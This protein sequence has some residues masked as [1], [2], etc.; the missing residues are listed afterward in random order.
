MFKGNHIIT[1]K[2]EHSSVINTFKW[3]E[4]F[5]F[6]VTYLDVNKDG[7]VEL[8]TLEKAIKENTVFISI[9]LINN[10]IGTI[11]DINELA[12]FANSKN[13]IFH[14]DVVQAVGHM[15]IDVNKLNC[16][17]L[18]ASSHKFNGPK[19]CG[20]LYKK[21]SVNI[22]P[23]IHGGE[24]EFG[25]RGV[26]DNLAQIEAMTIAL[27]GSIDY[28]TEYKAYTKS[29]R[30]RFL[31]ELKETGLN[32]VINGGDKILNSI[33]SISFRDFDGEVILHRLQFKG[34]YVSTGSACDSEKQ[35]VSHV[36]K[37]INLD[38]KFANG[39]IR[40]SIGNENTKEEM[41]ILCNE[42]SNIVIR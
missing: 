29:L 9:M 2:I 23:L 36:I 6:E 39:T 14:T 41:A 12:K 5:G 35:Q 22:T 32:F 17:M 33:I 31:E 27:T 8:E 20:F 16:D 30:D 10:E 1:S 40:V 19:G 34:I 24:Q 21:K 7:I 3:L 28:L 42:I 18:S 11:Q 13:I 25:L 37:A 26:T 15:N 4:E 38:P